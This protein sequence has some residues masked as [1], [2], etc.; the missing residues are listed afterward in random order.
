MGVHPL[1][2][3]GQA[4]VVWKREDAHILETCSYLT[5]GVR[6]LSSCVDLVS[7]C[8]EARIVKYPGVVVSPNAGADGGK[9]ISE[10]ILRMSLTGPPDPA[11]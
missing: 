7:S 3:F 11:G 5:P 2:A 9:P 4:V 6:N 8:S 1:D 10:A